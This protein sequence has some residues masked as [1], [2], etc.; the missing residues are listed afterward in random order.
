MNEINKQFVADQEKLVRNREIADL[1]RRLAPLVP[2][3]PTA[4]TMIRAAN[5]L[6]P[7]PLVPLTKEWLSFYMV[8]TKTGTSPRFMHAN[9]M[10]AV[11]EAERLA[12]K[13]PDKKFIVLHAFL[14]VSV[15]EQQEK[16]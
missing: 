13:H 15:A 8:W 3:L 12:R 5:V 14:K 4:A 11:A 6:D 2:C 1:L 7:P 16:A 10:A 9:E